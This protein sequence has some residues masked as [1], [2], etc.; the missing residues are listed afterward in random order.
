MNELSTHDQHSTSD[1]TTEKPNPK[2]TNG[3]LE[4]IR[5]AVIALLIVL[6]IRF[7]IAQPFIVSGASMDDTFENNQ[8]LIVDQVSYNFHQP[9]RGDVVIFKYP[10][11]PSKFFIKR[12]IGLPGETVV[13]SGLSVSIQNEKHPEGITLEEPYLDTVSKETYLTITLDENE[14]FVMGDNRDHSS[15]SRTWGVLPEENIMGRAILRLL[16]INNTGV[17]PGKHTFGSLTAD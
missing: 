17:F 7:F 12:V 10:L 1:Q 2:K 14:Y 6:P 3:F 16:P 9:E 8:Y 13:L 11:D 5:F 4:T 15:D